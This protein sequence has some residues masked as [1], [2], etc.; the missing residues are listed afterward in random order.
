ML[1][2]EVSID[3]IYDI[4]SDVLGESRLSAQI[5]WIPPADSFHAST[6]GIHRDHMH[7]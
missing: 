2:P 5:E 1:P 6:R 3:I 7:I 4:D